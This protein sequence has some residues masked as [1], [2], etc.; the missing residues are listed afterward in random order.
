MKVLQQITVPQESVNDQYA[1]VVGI[2]FETGSPVKKDDIVIELETSKAVLAIPAETDGFVEYFCAL[3][4]E[5]GINKLIVQ[6]AD[7]PVK[8]DHVITHQKQEQL[9][10]GQP[11]AEAE[12]PTSI[13]IGEYE[14][15]FSKKA[16]EIIVQNKI[17]RDRFKHLDF[18]TEDVVLDFINPIRIKT[19]Q[20]TEP[21][22]TA[23]V[24]R[25]HRVNT[26]KVY[27]QKISPAKKREIEYLSSVQGTNLVSTIY[28][29]ID[30]GSI[31][32]S[33]NPSLKY[34]KDSLLPVILY[35]TSRLLIKYPT[36]N[37]YFNEGALAT[38]KEINIGIAMDIDDGLKVVKVPH[39]DS[40]TIAGIE[41]TLFAL[42]NKY[43]DKTLETTD[44]T[45]ITFT[46]TDLSSQG[47]YFFTPLV[48]RGN[49][50]ILGLA[51]ADQRLNRVI[52]SLSFDHRVTEGKNATVFLYELK[53]RIES[54]SIGG[55]AKVNV[56]KIACYK[57]MKKLRD[58]LNN[59]GFI[60]VVNQDG[61]EKFICDSCLFSS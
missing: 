58:D 6:I 23:P 20:Q 44:L 8:T 13:F 55:G 11:H 41:D 33:V 53:E 40:K 29:D 38:Y 47:A 37:A 56:N 34:F 14:T 30:L 32:D 18:V 3:D 50:A 39:T 9:N 10:S 7:E 61:E 19:G 5:V 36:L 52:V 15:L 1:T 12:Q 22:L 49:G 26:E 51:K 42:S 16:E 4:E 60:K 43:L 28:M 27:I 2:P 45:D 24:K 35:E 21:Q 31:F 17:D 46:V 25:E 59:K 57:C 54:Y 48:N